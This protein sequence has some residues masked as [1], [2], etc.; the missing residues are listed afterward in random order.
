MTNNQN[1]ISI[2]E[3]N[4]KIL[5]RKIE[6]RRSLREQLENEFILAI[7]DSQIF[8]DCVSEHLFKSFSK[9]SDDCKNY[10]YQILIQ[11]HPYLLDCLSQNR[12]MDAIKC[13]NTMTSKVTKYYNEDEEDE[14]ERIYG[15]IE[16]RRDGLHLITN[17]S[18]NCEVL[19]TFINKALDDYKKQA[20]E[21]SERAHEEF[22]E[23]LRIQIPPAE[24]CISEKET[25]KQIV[26][27]PIDAEAMSAQLYQLA[28]LLW[29]ESMQRTAMYSFFTEEYINTPVDKEDIF[30]ALNDVLEA[31]WIGD[32]CIFSTQLPI[33]TEDSLPHDL[34][35]RL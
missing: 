23:F 27:S 35:V 5:I 33:M 21:E 28:R 31:I 10:A 20:R 8:P 22:E 29:S 6:L 7:S 16:S 18:S 15:T 30:N 24:T 34:P 14:D 11:N 4:L 3:A 32:E 17:D 9:L 19:N 13:I 2:M 1:Q 26:A 25:L 12:T